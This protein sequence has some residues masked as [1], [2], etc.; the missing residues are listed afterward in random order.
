[1]K[2]TVAIMRCCWRSV[3]CLA[4]LVHVNCNIRLMCISPISLCSRDSREVC[5]QE[6]IIYSL[7]PQCLWYSIQTLLP[8]TKQGHEKTL[9][10]YLHIHDIS[11]KFPAINPGPAEGQ[12][13]HGW[14]YFPLQIAK[15]PQD[16]AKQKSWA[17]KNIHDVIALWNPLSNISISLRNDLNAHDIKVVNEQKSPKTYVILVQKC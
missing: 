10:I 4:D 8:S 3:S 17:M 5:S 13:T 16:K 6:C 2:W 11:G 7:Y 12:I 1:M 15:A 14:N 9:V